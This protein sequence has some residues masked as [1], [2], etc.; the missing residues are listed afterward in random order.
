MLLLLPLLARAAQHGA[1]GTIFKM[2]HSHGWQVGATC[3]LGVSWGW[4]PCFLS[5]L[6]F[7]WTAWAF[8]QHGDWITRASYEN[9]AKVRGISCPSLGCHSVTSEVLCWSKQSQWPL[10]LKGNGKVLEKHVDGLLW[11]FLDNICF[12]GEPKA[13]FRLSMS[14][15]KS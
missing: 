9:M 7:P 3:L 1:K 10:R 13:C 5:P 2:A 6:A 12:T 11:T 14:V 4:E 15:Y 8:L